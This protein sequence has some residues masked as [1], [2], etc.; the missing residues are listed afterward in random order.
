MD[1]TRIVEEQ[2]SFFNTG[3]TRDYEYRMEMLGRLEKAVKENE[4]AICD[5]LREDL[6]RT[7]NESYMAEIGPVLSEIRYHKKHLKKWMD[8]RHVLTGLVQMPGRSR[9]IP[10]PYGLVL[11]VSPWN[12]PFNMCFQALTGAI[13]AG[14]CAVIKPSSYAPASSHVIADICRN[15]FDSAYVTVIEGGR[16]ENAALFDQRFDSIFFTGSVSV[17]KTVLEAAAKNLTPVTLEL[18]GKS[19]VIIDESA[20]IRLAARRVM[21]GKVLNAGQTC[22]APDYVMIAESKKDEFVEECRKALERFFPDGDYSGMPSIINEKHVA[23]LAGLIEKE[24]AVIG[25]S[26]DADSRIIE[27]TVMT[28]ITYDSPSMQEEI[29]GPLLPVMTYPD[30]DIESCIR[31][32][33]S[34]EKPLA[35]YLFTR[36]KEVK[37]KVFACCSFGG[38]CVNDVIMHMVSH[39]MPFGGVGSSGMGSYHGKQSFD[40]F[41]HYRSILESGSLI[42]LPLRYRPYT[43]AKNTLIRKAF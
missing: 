15:T 28:D 23:R 16:R 6:H 11:I 42:D 32:I 7:D 24:K 12:Y 31:F 35:L 14:N 29:F 4:Q 2:R 10:E 13:S 22:I 8:S 1:I 37:K 20:D 43:K 26:V 25:G 27:P 30:G 41:T 9:I 5:A 3:I 34:R 21:F 33:N 19:P 36:D 38:G 18:G 39:S 17:G 40:T